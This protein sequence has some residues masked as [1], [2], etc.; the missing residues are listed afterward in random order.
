MNLKAVNRNERETSLQIVEIPY[1]HFTEDT[2]L[3]V[4]GSQMSLEKYEGQKSISARIGSG[5]ITEFCNNG[6]S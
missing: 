1:S 2:F 5:L 3:R 4:K 6:S